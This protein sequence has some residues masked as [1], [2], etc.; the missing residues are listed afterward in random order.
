MIRYERPS[1][2]LVALTIKMVVQPTMQ[3]KAYIRSR[4]HSAF[5][6]RLNAISH[7][8]VRRVERRRSSVGALRLHTRQNFRPTPA[9]HL[10]LC[11][12]VASSI[13]LEPPRC[14]HPR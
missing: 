8:Y 14:S 3:A 10:E 11:L 5:A 12:P 2:P 13:T 6:S 7:L 1:Y 4:L 9:A